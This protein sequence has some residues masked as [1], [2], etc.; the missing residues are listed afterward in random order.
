MKY[1]RK[2]K[3]QSEIQMK[4]ILAYIYLKKQKTMIQILTWDIIRIMHN[5]IN[6]FFIDKLSK[7]QCCFTKGLET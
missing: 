1:L 4:E 2:Q 6:Y 3:Y 5:Q 7:H